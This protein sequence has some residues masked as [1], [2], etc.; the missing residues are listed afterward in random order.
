[1]RSKNIQAKFKAI[2]N[3][4]IHKIKYNQSSTIA[5]LKS[6][7]KPT[8]EEPVVQSPKAK[9]PVAPKRV[10]ESPGQAD[11]LARINKEQE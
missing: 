5:L 10:I 11:K 6:L 7:N 4:V 2:D 9:S 8:T 3:L 1:M